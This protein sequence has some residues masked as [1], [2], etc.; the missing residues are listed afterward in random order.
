M[1]LMPGTLDKI[2]DHLI[3]SRRYD[4]VEFHVTIKDTD[5]KKLRDSRH[6]TGRRV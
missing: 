4:G 2:D 3:T 1:C 5:S 6:P